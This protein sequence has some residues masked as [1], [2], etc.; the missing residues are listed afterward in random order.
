MEK[1]DFRD[2]FS[3]TDVRFSISRL[4]PT[5]FSSFYEQTPLMDLFM[6]SSL[7]HTHT[8]VTNQW[9]FFRSLF[10]SLYLFNNPSIFEQK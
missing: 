4:F 2:F 6:F 5:I 9:L 7:A 8:R 1:N 10:M 3:F